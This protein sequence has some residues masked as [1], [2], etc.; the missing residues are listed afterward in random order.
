MSTFKT[1][2][3]DWVL[4]VNLPVKKA[5]KLATDGKVDLFDVWEGRVQRELADPETLVN[6]L[7]VMCKDQADAAKVSELD[8]AKM[9]RGD[10]LEH[11]ANA[12]SEAIIDFF[13]SRQCQTLNKALAK[14]QQVVNQAFEILNAELDKP[15][16]PLTL[17]ESSTSGAESS[18]STLSI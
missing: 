1:A 8:F 7:W 15:L 5:V 2:Q 10:V 17:K 4:E 16:A 14:G 12:L 9:F 3:R 6:V 18:V 11:A 13:P